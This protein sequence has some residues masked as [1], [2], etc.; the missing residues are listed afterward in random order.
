MHVLVMAKAPVPGRVKTRLCPPCTPEQAAGLAAAALRDTVT[1]A[2]ASRADRVVVALDGAPPAWLPSRV[3]VVAQRGRGLADRLANAWDDVG[4]PG[5]QIGMDTPHVTPALLDHARGLLDG[6]GAVLGPAEDG[7]W[8]AIGLHRPDARVFEGI[9][10]SRAWTGA[11]QRRR[12]L[13]LGLDVCLLPTLRDVDTIADAAAVASLAP[14]S[15][16]A[17]ALARWQLEAA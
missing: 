9:E 11:R 7:G 14:D 4:G 3:E 2:L 6:V 15:E 12:L 10:M 16:F 1:A 13:S 17:A 5:V 8:W